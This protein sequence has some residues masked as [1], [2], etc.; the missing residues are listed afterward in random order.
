MEQCLTSRGKTQKKFFWGGK[1]GGG[2]G[3]GGAKLGSKLEFLPFPQGCIISFL[4]I[5]HDYNLGQCLISSRA[6][7]S[8]KIFVFQIIA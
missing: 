4:D 8:K 6:E 1:G 3:E 5:A 2:G 7:T